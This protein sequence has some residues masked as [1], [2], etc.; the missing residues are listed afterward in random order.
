MHR[1]YKDVAGIQ[2]AYPHLS[3][4]DI[5]EALDDCYVNQAAVRDRRADLVALLGTEPFPARIVVR[6]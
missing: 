5:E 3:R 1:L 6:G 2:G 4:A